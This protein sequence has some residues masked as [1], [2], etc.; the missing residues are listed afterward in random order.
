MNIHGLSRFFQTIDWLL[1]GAIVCIT[2][3]GLITM[4][5]FG[6]VNTFFDRQVIWLVVSLVVFFVIANFDVSFLR[7]TSVVMI[8][9]VAILI[10]LGLLFIVGSV[11]SGSQS[12]FNLGLFSVQPAE[13]AK[14]AL[15]ILLAKYFSKRHVEIKLFQHI[16]VS[17]IYAGILFLLI[18]AQGDFGS[19][20]IIFAIWLGMVVFSGISKKHIA[21]IFILGAAAFGALWMGVFEDYQKQR[22][23]SFA[24]PLQDVQGTGY[25]ALQSTITVGSGQVL[26]KGIGYGTQSRLKFLPEYQTDF[27]FAAFAEEWGFI[28]TVFLL[29]LYLFVLWRII[30]HALRARTNFETLFA[31]GLVILF[32]SHMI[33]HVGMNIGLMPVTGITIPFMSYGGTNLL[34]SFVGVGLLMAMRRF[35][36][37][38]HRDRLK[39]EFLGA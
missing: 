26:G 15:I 36:R 23:I 38:A 6:D 29:L 35:E 16:L 39:N 1:L 10:L 24:R 20:I 3:A 19:A 11:F 14:L 22:I 30:L 27:I 2:G 21:F 18:L 28:G 4:Y 37:P 17:G 31:V 9:F 33:V 13:F 34:A 8:I 7:R 32:L 12:W 25:H 5:S